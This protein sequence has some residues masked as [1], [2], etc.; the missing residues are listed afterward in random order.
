MCG[1]Y[2]SE[3]KKYILPKNGMKLRDIKEAG[4]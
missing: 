2:F 1:H 3:G 4:K